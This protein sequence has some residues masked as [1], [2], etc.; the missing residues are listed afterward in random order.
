MIKNGKH[1]AYRLN[2]RTY[3]CVKDITLDYVG[4]K[5]KSSVIW[6]LREGA[7]RFSE[8][9]KEIHDI[10]EQSLVRQLQALEN[11]KVIKREVFGTKPPLRVVYSLT[12][13]GE[14]LIPLL[15]AMGRWGEG[16]GEK[17]GK[18]VEL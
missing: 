6:S 18:L 16:L 11:K 4:G 5:W 3:H 17:D 14:T 7:L 15:V 1:V 9:Q 8:I 2:G 12:P 13:L 10:T